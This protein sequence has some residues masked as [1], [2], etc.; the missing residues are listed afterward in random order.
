M[1]KMLFMTSLTGSVISLLLILLK[2]RLVPKL[3]GTWYYHI[4]LLSL[5]LFVVPIQ[6]NVGGLLPQ[7]VIIEEGAPVQQ[8]AGLTVHT[9]PTPG[10]IVPAAAG[11]TAGQRH[12]PVPDVGQW[13]LGIWAAGFV[14]MLG[15]YLWGYFR[16][17]NKVT[18]NSP[19]GKAEN[20]DVVVSSY[21]HSPI[22]IGFF[23]PAIVIPQAE[24]SPYDY[25]LALKHEL[26][27]HKQKDAWCKLLAVL[28]N[29]LHWFNPLTYFMVRNISEA[30]EYACDEKVTRDMEWDEKK[31]YSDMILNF[32]CHA[33]PALSSSLARNKKQLFRR[34]ELIMKTGTKSKKLLGV[35]LAAVM[36]AGSVMATSLVFAEELKPLSRFGGAFVTHYDPSK[37]LEVNVLNTLDIHYDAPLPLLRVYTMPGTT[38][39]DVNGRKIDTYNRTEPYYGVEKEWKEKNF[40]IE[41]M[42]TKTLSIEGKDVIVA[43][44]DQAA[45]YR[46][47]K[48]IEK[49]IRNQITFELSYRDDIFDYDHQAF[50]NQL[51]SR[52]AYVINEVVTPENFNPFIFH[53][54]NGDFLGEKILTKFDKKEKISDIF[55]QKTIIPQNIDG[56]Q[57]AQLGDS[58]VIGS[59]ETLAIDIKETTDKM[60][61]VNWAIIN[62]TTGELVDWMPSAPGGYRFI[63]TP[64]EAYANHTFKVIMSGEK[65]DT[66]IIEIFTYR[67]GASEAASDGQTT[68]KL[69][70]K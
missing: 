60:P 46:D 33:S 17:K 28:V 39:I 70:E 4:C 14:L 15:R 36:M 66:A 37:S 27:H 44:A 7:P 40:A 63:Y 62:V 25:R 54:Q 41:T 58:F 16:F 69:D 23:K 42:T 32:A 43:F 3:G 47:D 6:V 26:T 50:I 38:Y 11:Q 55:N 49:M 1:I 13:M 45:A 51:I 68:T 19:I 22:L 64:R 34:F 59:G 29:S 56:H 12:L 67:T 30:C 61:K 24:I 10:E 53:R 57:G 9:A 8:Q 2:T 35:L 31:R 21:V 20:L 48:V 65:S 18:Q 5:V 52:G